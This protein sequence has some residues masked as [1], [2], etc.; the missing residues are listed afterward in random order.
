M[1]RSTANLIIQTSPNNPPNID[2]LK[3]AI[4][5]CKLEFEWIESF[6]VIN[7]CYKDNLINEYKDIIN[8]SY[9]SIETIYGFTKKEVKT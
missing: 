8:D 9:D 3:D 1:A 2:I 4:Y 6:T 5:S 7:E